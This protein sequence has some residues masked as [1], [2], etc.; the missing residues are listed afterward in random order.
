MFRV[1][2][3]FPPYGVFG[4][5]ALF[6]CVQQPP[7]RIEATP[8]PW[9]CVSATQNVQSCFVSSDFWTSFLTCTLRLSSRCVVCVTPRDSPSGDPTRTR[10]VAEPA[11]VWQRQGEVATEHPLRGLAHHGSTVPSR[12]THCSGLCQ[13]R[14]GSHCRRC[15][16][17]H[18]CISFALEHRR[19]SEVVVRNDGGR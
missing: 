14:N 11:S 3:P 17:A 4:F 2:P 13:A 10:R 16:D 18:A 6:G 9:A 15:T 1:C 5:R 8:R 12:M 19:K 7:C